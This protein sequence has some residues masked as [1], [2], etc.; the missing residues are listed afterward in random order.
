MVARTLFIRSA[1]LALVLA[2]LAATP[3]AL[4][5]AAPAVAVAGIP[6]AADEG[7]GGEPIEY[8]RPPR[9]QWPAEIEAWVEAHSQARGVYQTTVDNTTWVLV[10]WGP[11]PTGGYTV[12]VQSAERLSEGEVLFHVRLS[13]PPPDVAV[14]QVITYPF[15]LVTLE[16][17][18]AELRFEFTGAPW[19]DG[20]DGSEDPGGP[21]P[22][23][24]VLTD[25]RGHWAEADI[26]RA[27]AAGFVDG[28]P[29]ATF[30]PDAPVTRAEFVQM[31]AGAFGIQA[32][33][34]V[35]AA[36]SDTAGH[37]AQ[38]VIAAAAGRGIVTGQADGTFAPDRPIR[39]VELAAMLVR[40][41]GRAGEAAAYADAAAAAFNDVGH[42]PAELRGYVGL[43]AELGI[44]AGYPEGGFEPDRSA[45]RAE[46]V[47]LIGRALAAR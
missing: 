35:D 2:A 41:L 6:V 34:P 33:A 23:A 17:A 30:R 19:N 5:A 18:D 25:M 32:Q 24:P 36:F 42:L 13:A 3:L 28:Y 39:R 4:V 43:A 1:A 16:A 38:A 22:P 20:D 29:D 37:W 12:A 9:S 44:L 40:A 8:D 21:P 47:V 15:D 27:V 14:I 31:L 10:A 7:E 11:K 46:A 26:T 45:T